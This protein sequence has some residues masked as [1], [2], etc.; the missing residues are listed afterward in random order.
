MRKLIL[1]YSICIALFTACGNSVVSPEQIEK[2]PS[3]YPDY[4]GVTIPATIAPMNFSYTDTSYER[5]DVIVKGCQGK[6][7]HINAKHVNFSEKEWKQLL[8]SNQGDSLLF[9][10]SIK[11]EGKW[12]T[13]KPFPMYISPHPID[14]GL[15]Y[16]KIA[17]GYEVYSRMGIYERDLS[18]HKE[19]PL[20]ENTLVK[21]MCVNCHAFNRT[22]P[23]HF[24]L[25]IRGTHGATFMRTDNKDEYL[26]TKT[27]Q[28]IAACVYPYWHP[29]GEY[30]AYSTNNTRQ[31]FHT[32]K[33]ER[34]EVLD[35]ESDIV[36][37]H[38]A[39]HRLLLCDSL[40][41]KDR[42][43]TFPAFSPDGRTLYFCSAEAKKIPEE[44]KEIRYN[45]C[46]I[47]FDPSAG[48]FGSR[49]DTLVNAEALGKS[50]SFPRP[51]YDGKYIMF[52]LSDYGNFS[53]WHKDADLYMTD[54]QTGTSRRPPRAIR[55]K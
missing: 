37:Y 31:S 25:H 13:Y 1:L 47:D 44:Y 34:V 8:I 46:S 33:D 27:D 32:V 43:E 19:R 12:S 16:R 52:T 5:I 26:N 40:Q 17:P 29:G 55:S 28:T 4:I 6:E 2:Y 3:I 22:D 18:S 49:I 35:L 20:V 41:K 42:F 9:T 23:S 38:P 21:G 50:V 15:V 51:S 54:L 45:L 30:I 11:Q 7:V 24:S 39:D 36:V 10:V 53:I 48:T 14:Y